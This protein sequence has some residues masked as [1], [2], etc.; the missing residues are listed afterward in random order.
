MECE[1]NGTASA[2]SVLPVAPPRAYNG[3]IGSLPMNGSLVTDDDRGTNYSAAVGNNRSH[4]VNLADADEQAAAAGICVSDF[5][6]SFPDVSKYKRL[7][8]SIIF[9]FSYFSK[10]LSIA[11]LSPPTLL[12]YFTLNHLKSLYVNHQ[13]FPSSP[14]EKKFSDPFF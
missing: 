5:R 14:K 13:S 12:A 6:S 7:E 3:S 8:V 9:Q 4:R 10:L 11:Q 2:T 1:N